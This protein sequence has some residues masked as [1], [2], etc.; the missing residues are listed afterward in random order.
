MIG[1]RR[2]TERRFALLRYSR[3]VERYAISLGPG[4]LRQ[5]LPT[6]IHIAETEADVAPEESENPFADVESA[7]LHQAVEQRRREFLTTRCC[8]HAALEAAGA[9]PEALLRGAQGQ[10]LWPDGVIGS[11]THFSARTDRGK[12]YRGAAVT[13]TDKYA[14][15]GIDAELGKP[16]P[17]GLPEMITSRTERRSAAK[18]FETVPELPVSRL[19]FSIKE[20]F[21]KARFPVS[22][23]F[24]DFL[25]VE[26]DFAQSERCVPELTPEYAEYAA[27]G[28]S[29]SGTF[30]ASVVNPARSHRSLPDA[31]EGR[32][33][34]GGDR[35]LTA[36]MLER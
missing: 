21:Y 11:L 23:S 10:P 20:S 14:L 2:S 36:V 28:M 1:D 26:I 18:L 5:L 6:A 3:F 29:V 24:L 22:G 30:A 8:A 27:D 31:L 16:L 13:T 15:L 33:L 12:V 9:P 4:S 34:V 32:F 25:D 35:I 17:R 19:M 7:G